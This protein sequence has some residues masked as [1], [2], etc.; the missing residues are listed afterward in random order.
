MSPT[1]GPGAAVPALEHLDW[2]DLEPQLDGNGVAVTAPLLD[3][4]QC[5][6]MIEVFDD[7]SAFRSTVD[8]AR[9]SFGQGRY[10]YFADPL[11]ALV[12]DLRTAAAA[13]E[14]SSD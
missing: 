14:Q 11:P 8:M 2:D 9:L 13:L 10:R 1:T 3:A 7:D 12:A 6:Q 5:R 4:E